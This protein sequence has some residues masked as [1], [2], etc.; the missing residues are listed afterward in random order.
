MAREWRGKTGFQIEGWSTA[1]VDVTRHFNLALAESGC[2][3]STFACVTS[4]M[5]CR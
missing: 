2:A 1:S 4:G 3:Y 5:E